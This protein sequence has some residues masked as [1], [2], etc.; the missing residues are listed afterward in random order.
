MIKPKL[1]TIYTNNSKHEILT[2]HTKK[3]I[4]DFL[5]KMKSDTDSMVT[6]FESHG[7]DV[8]SPS[9]EYCTKEESYYAGYM[10]AL[11]L[12]TAH[13]ERSGKKRKH[14]KKVE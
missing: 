13:L 8:E 6:L 4:L 12:C 1:K 3:N 7:T 14:V 11:T 5:E 2:V 9:L 10:D